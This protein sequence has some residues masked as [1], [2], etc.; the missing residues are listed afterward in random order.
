MTKL[1]K[2]E[3]AVEQCPSCKGK[4]YCKKK[5][6]S[7]KYPEKLQWQDE[8]G[9]AHYSYDFKTDTTSC[10]GT[11]EKIEATVQKIQSQTI[12]L[13][14]IKLDQAMLER[15]L[16]LSNKTTYI[17]MAIEYGVR[18]VLGSD[19]NP[20]HVGMYVN[21]IASKLLNVSNL[22]QILEDIGGSNES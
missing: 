8:D 5:P 10:A 18:E 6:A 20:Q 16:M 19:A 11:K 2:V 3:G 13:S 4:I 9:K 14:D 7:G 22:A 21:N 17:L 15:V 12:K 1:N